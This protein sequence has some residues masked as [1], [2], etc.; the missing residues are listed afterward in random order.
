MDFAPKN[1]GTA[2]NVHFGMLCCNQGAVK[3]IRD[4]NLPRRLES[5]Y[6]SD[7][8]EAECFMKHARQ[9]NNGMAMSSLV[10]EKGWTNRA[11]N[12]KV[13]AMLTAS[14]QLFR[15]IGLSTPAKGETP[16]CMQTCFL[17]GEQV[18]TWRM[19]N[20]RRKI[21]E[22]ERKM[23]HKVFSDLHRVITRDSNN[24]CLKSFIGAKQCVEEKLKNK[25]WDVN[26][27]IHANESPSNLVHAGR[28]NAPTVDEVA[29]LMPNNEITK[30][31]NR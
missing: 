15:R 8:K 9:F 22:G 16:K 5:L 26:M 12:N 29:I 7:S 31:H 10:C 25:I 30:H 21:E 13:D 23:C 4:Y 11:H 20:I 27:A 17:W 18:T 2:N 19:E 3:G 24:K 6:T 14:G 1:K 28:L